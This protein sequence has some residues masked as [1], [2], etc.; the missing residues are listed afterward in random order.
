MRYCLYILLLLSLLSC[1]NVNKAHLRQLSLLTRQNDSLS[2]S[3]SA[4]SDTSIIKLIN[5]YTQFLVNFQ[6]TCSDTLN[7]A[8]A[9]SLLNFYGNIQLLKKYISKKKELRNKLS[10]Q[11]TQLINLKTDLEKGNKLTSDFYSIYCNE[12]NNLQYLGSVI[13]KSKALVEKRVEQENNLN[14]ELADILK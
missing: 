5:N 6:A 12:R 8:Q 14:E 10:A 11:K 7:T 1:S 2:K 9:E 3:I 13:T 4:E